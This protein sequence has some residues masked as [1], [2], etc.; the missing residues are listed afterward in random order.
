MDKKTVLVIAGSGT[1]A[2][3]LI[4]ALDTESELI[5]SIPDAMEIKAPRQFDD[6]HWMEQQKHQ[7]YGPIKKR[8]KGKHKKWQRLR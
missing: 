6:F 1:I 4:E 3:R 2:T 5:D 7:P 8:G